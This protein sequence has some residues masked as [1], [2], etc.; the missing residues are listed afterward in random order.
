MPN[1]VIINGGVAVRGPYHTGALGSPA[2]HGCIRLSVANSKTFYNLV[3]RHGLKFTRVAVFGRPNWRGGGEVA[4]RSASRKKSYA[5]RQDNWFFGYN[6]SASDDPNT[7]YVQPKKKAG[8]KNYAYVY[9]DGVPMKVRRKKNGDYVMLKQP[10]R[11][12]YNTYGSAN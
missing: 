6:D 4:S 7:V 9:V 12:Y 10:R 2:S 1:A 11:T 8:S 3:E 5:A